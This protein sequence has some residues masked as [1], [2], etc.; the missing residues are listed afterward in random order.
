M[1]DFITLYH[2]T[3][4]ADSISFLDP[5]YCKPCQGGQK[6][7]IYFTNSL[8]AC[9]DMKVCMLY[10]GRIVHGPYVTKIPF[11]NIFYP[12][13]R[14]DIALNPEII[15]DLVDGLRKFYSKN[16]FSNSKIKLTMPSHT[17]TWDPY[18]RNALCP[19]LDDIEITELEF[20]KD[21]CFVYYKCTDSQNKSIQKRELSSHMDNDFGIADTLIEFL[22]E[23]DEDFRKH[24]NQNLRDSVEI[25]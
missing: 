1:S 13:W 23:K 17:A 16:S 15:D 2:L 19:N 5:K 22:C 9:K 10:H 20:A 12:D 4:S 18:N 8:R 11:D 14:I 25:S 24:Y 3:N 7:G 6:E 21:K